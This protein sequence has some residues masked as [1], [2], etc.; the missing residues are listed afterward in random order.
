MTRRDLTDEQIEARMPKKAGRPAMPAAQAVAV[1]LNG[2][3][4]APEVVARATTTTTTIYRRRPIAATHQKRRA[5]AAPLRRRRH[6]AH[7]GLLRRHATH[8]A[9]TI[10]DL[11]LPCD[12]P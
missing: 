6:P 11:L 2:E 9:T 10:S 5:T 8:D 7:A 3:E 4:T 12:R 1:V